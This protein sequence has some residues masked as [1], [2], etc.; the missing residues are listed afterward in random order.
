[1][2][3]WGTVLAIFWSFFPLAAEDLAA[4]AGTVLAAGLALAAARW[5]TARGGGARAEVHPSCC[6]LLS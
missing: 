6:G 1:M 5:E 2:G 4:A 3:G